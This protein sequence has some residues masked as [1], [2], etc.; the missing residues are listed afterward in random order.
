MAMPELPDE[1]IS[2]KEDPIWVLPLAWLLV[3]SRKLL[4]FLLYLGIGL[5]IV[6]MLWIGLVGH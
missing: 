2:P 1:P 3:I 5:A 6:L 4:L